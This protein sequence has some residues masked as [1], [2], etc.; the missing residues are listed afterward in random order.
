MG[1]KVKSGDTLTKI[2]KDHNLSLDTLLAMNNMTREQANKIQI[3]QD[4]NVD[5]GPSAKEDWRPPQFGANSSFPNLRPKSNPVPTPYKPDYSEQDYLKDNAASIQEQLIAEKYNVG[6]WGADG[7]WGRSSQ[8][9]L[10]QALADGYQLKN[11]KLVK[12]Q[13]IP[14]NSAIAGN[15][16]DAAVMQALSSEPRS[17]VKPDQPSKVSLV[18]K[19]TPVPKPTP[20]TEF[21]DYLFR[22][23][24]TNPIT[25]AINTIRPIISGYFGKKSAW[26]DGPTNVKKQGLGLALKFKPTNP[27]DLKRGVDEET[28]KPYVQWQILSDSDDN[29]L[30]KQINGGFQVHPDK[31]TQEETAYIKANPK[32]VQQLLLDQGIDIGSDTPDGKWGKNSQAAWLEAKRRGY[33]LENGKLVD[34]SRGRV[35]RAAYHPGEHILGGYTIREYEDG[36]YQIRDEYNFSNSGSKYSDKLVDAGSENGAYERTRSRVGNLLGDKSFPI[37]WTISKDEVDSWRGEYERDPNMVKYDTK[38]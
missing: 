33:A 23:G 27:K 15:S 14:R 21:S 13:L 24:Q 26:E 18:Q 12:P 6:K 3:G 17:D 28:G 8:A 35:M 9:A 29:Y 2:A 34:R 19:S 25:N 5:A 37:R 4:I 11:G 16:T 1:Y 36:S 38:R 22:S 31:I 20:S 7:K 10:D 32:A 30:W